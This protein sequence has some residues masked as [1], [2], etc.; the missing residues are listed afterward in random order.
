MTYGEN[1]AF[2]SFVLIFELCGN[3][4][5]CN[6]SHSSEVHFRLQKCLFVFITLELYYYIYIYIRR[7]QLR[8]F[9]YNYLQYGK[10][11]Q[12]IFKNDI[13]PKKL[14]G[15]PYEGNSYCYY[16]KGSSY[17]PR[18]LLSVKLRYVCIKCCYKCLKCCYR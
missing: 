10:E 9:L 18:D 2:L 14:H 7:T 17:S 6:F 16:L 15:I 5:T 4:C 11:E 12:E 13:R 1:V 8:S 3:I